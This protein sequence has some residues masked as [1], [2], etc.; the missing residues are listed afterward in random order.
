MLGQQQEKS[1]IDYEIDPLVR[2]D[3]ERQAFALYIVEQRY[4]Q[5][6]AQKERSLASALCGA[7]EVCVHTSV[8]HRD[9]CV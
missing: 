7:P 1:T 3:Q 5:E 9:P 4:F 6:G 2:L 8:R